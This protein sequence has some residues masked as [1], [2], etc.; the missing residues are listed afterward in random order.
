M[1]RLVVV[2]A[3]ASV[4]VGGLLAAPAVAAP[5]SAGVPAGTIAWGP[6]SSSSLQKAGAQCGYLKVPLD[7][8]KP[9][10]KKIEIAV[11]RVKHKVPDSQYQGIMIVNPGGPGGSGLGLSRLG[12]NVPNHAGDAYDWIGFDPRGV[13]SSKPALSCLP[14]YFSYDRPNYIP[15]TP[16]LER[17]WL[18]RSK[19]Y[20]DACGRNNGAL[21]NHMKTTDSARDMDAIRKALG[22]QQ[23]N[24]YGFSY[25]TYLGQVYSTLFPKRVRR[26][27][28]DSNVDPRNVWYKAN[29]NQDV[30]FDRNIKIWF[31]WLAKYDSVYH[32]GSSEAAV[33]KLFYQ[34]R[35]KLDRHAAGGLIGGDEWTDIFLE[36]GY[37]RMT[38]VD[39]GNAFAGW[40][41]HHDW[42]TLKAE[43]DST[44]G[45]GNDN[46][47]AV[48]LAVQCSD[49]QWPQHW[50]KWRRDNWRTY[51]KAPFET[52]DNAWYNAPCLYWPA[53][54]GIPVHVN[55]K[56]VAG[57]LLIDETLDAATPYEGS[58]EVRKLFPK[59]SLIAEPGGATHADSLWGDACVD[60]K[61]ADYLATG[62]LPPRI[63]GNHADVLCAPNPDPVPGASAAAA[64]QQASQ[65]AAVPQSLRPT[66]MVR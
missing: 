54:P 25:G 61:I 64:P 39:L 42:K 33:Q 12:Q 18:Q 63:P 59:A 1:K 6:C 21:L 53:K 48:Y 38:W 19:A 26:M 10:G 31:T 2:A 24:Y 65:A 49:V 4:M 20:A 9:S 30:A 46:G 52:W 28:L 37:Y 34:Q 50:N 5:A 32:L 3:A 40:I 47:F 62:A 51:A 66:V 27:V 57:A 36:A 13:G 44:S 16:G 56:H 14:N 8:S 17:I 55:G 45:I 23:I 58:L 11:S 60:N 29:L 43:Y 15:T 7:Y 22:K 35:D 41:H